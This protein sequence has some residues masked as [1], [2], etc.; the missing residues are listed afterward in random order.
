MSAPV[1]FGTCSHCKTSE[2][3]FETGKCAHCTIKELRA[4][5]I[6]VPRSVLF[7]YNIGD[8]AIVVAAPDIVVQIGA[9]KKSSEGL[10][11]YGAWWQDGKRLEEWF[12]AWELKKGG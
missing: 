2:Q 8:K 5:I 7:D 3:L 10:Q 1:T 4:R 9:M 11:Y 6:Q 12:Y